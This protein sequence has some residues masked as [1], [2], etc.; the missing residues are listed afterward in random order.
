MRGLAPSQDFDVLPCLC[1]S[2]MAWYGIW[3]IIGESWNL[4]RTPYENGKRED[5]HGP[6]PKKMP[7]VAALEPKR[8][9]E[10]QSIEAVGGIFVINGCKLH[11][12][13]GVL[14]KRMKRKT[15]DQSLLE[16]T[17]SKSVFWLFGWFSPTFGTLRAFGLPGF[18]SMVQAWNAGLSKAPPEDQESSSRKILWVWGR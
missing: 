2:Y 11:G 13:V 7:G 6:S 18:T 4:Y 1:W 17:L 3:P 5:G 8:P 12:R 15:S 16:E 10:Y 9:W 14:K